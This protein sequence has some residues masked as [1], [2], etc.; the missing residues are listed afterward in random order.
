MSKALKDILNN[1]KKFNDL[2]KSVF[3]S[4]DTDRSGE[5]DA[6]ELEKVMKMMASDM[7]YESPSSEE[8][9]EVFQNLDTDNS[10]KI[11]FLEFKML[12]KDVLEV[13]IESADY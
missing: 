5:I 10:G 2:A 1:D 9:L 8:I 12:I 4:V 6:E 3:D 13:M 11:D 7:S